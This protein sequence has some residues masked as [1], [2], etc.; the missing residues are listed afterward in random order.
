MKKIV[1]IFLLI[2]IMTVFASCADNG[3]GD[4]PVPLGTNLS[5]TEPTTAPSTQ[6]GYALT[7]DPNATV[8]WGMTT[9]FIPTEYTTPTYPTVSIPAVTDD[10]NTTGIIPNISQVTNNGTTNTTNNGGNT[11]P[12]NNNNTGPTV[13]D[14]IDNTV[15]DASEVTS[16]AA[17]QP[18]VVAI[19]SSSMS[20]DKT[21]KF[22]GNASIEFSSNGWDGTIIAKSGTA[23]VIYGGESFNAP[24]SVSASFNGQGNYEIVINI[25]SLE[26]P[27][28]SDGITVKI[29]AGF[30]ENSAGTLY[31]MEISRKI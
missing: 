3:D 24:C 9:A 11:G 4:T 10:K 31:S 27:A 2:A 19:S 5:N 16:S 12:T 28:G 18:K 26:I 13:S 30:I 14:G 21:G 1:A 23:T 22:L 17:R 8:Y 29:P 20:N 15:P 7:T 25:A 6:A